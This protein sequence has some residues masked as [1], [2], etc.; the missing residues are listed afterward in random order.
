[1]RKTNSKKLIASFLLSSTL[2]GCVSIQPAP[3]VTVCAP[4]NDPTDF[5]MEQPAGFCK[6]TMSSLERTIT[7]EEWRNRVRNS[8]MV[9]SED[10]VKLLT[11]VKKTCR[12]TNNECTDMKAP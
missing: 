11:Y 8:V 10:W 5:V 6:H 1:M 9:S 12:Q 7:G 2:T 4:L 3:N